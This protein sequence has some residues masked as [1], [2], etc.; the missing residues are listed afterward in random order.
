MN[1][2]MGYILIIIGLIIVLWGI[3]IIIKPKAAEKQHIILEQPIRLEKKSDEKL[4]NPNKLS[5]NENV[6]STLPIKQDYFD[7]N[8]AKGDAF[9]KF[10]VKN[11]D[12]KY[13]ILQEWRSDKYVDGIY[14]I[15]NHFPD[16]EVIFNFKSKNIHEAFAI[17]CKW[18]KS[19]YKNGIE[20]A[21]NYQ[22]VN[23]KEYSEKLE[24]PVF[25]VIGVGG[26]PGKPQELFIVPLQKMNS[27]VISKSELE[28]YSKDISKPQFYWDSEKT[29]L[30]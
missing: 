13:F 25:V 10:V 14:A 6:K 26:E 2:K 7:E 3:K 4:T 30:R 19:Y 8:K 20:W 22:I 27:K 18:R 24:I 12:P 5:E 23:Y 1:N 11:F 17:E 29:V 21:E 15:S 16:L 28:K 9:E